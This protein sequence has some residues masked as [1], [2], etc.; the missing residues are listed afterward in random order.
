MASE[1][2]IEFIITQ[3]RQ[4]C[5]HTF[6]KK[7]DTTNVGLGA[8]IRCLMKHD[9]K[10]T[11]GQISEEMNV[12]TA[13]VAALLKKMEQRGWLVREKDATDKRIT[14]VKLTS[15]GMAIGVTMRKNIR[16]QIATLIDEIGV[17]KLMDFMETRAKIFELVDHSKFWL[18]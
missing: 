7:N 13:R 17:E 3:Y 9:G 12:S 18:H 6:W 16:Q 1:E 14:L 8:V 15:E 2:Q 11:S 5:P 4:S 10:A